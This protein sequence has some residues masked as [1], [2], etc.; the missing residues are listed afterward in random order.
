MAHILQTKTPMHFLN[1]NKDALVA[2]FVGKPLNALRTPAFIVDRAVF[3]ENCRKMHANARDWGATFRGHLKTHKTVEGTRLQLVSDIG[4]TSAVVV[5]TLM[6]AWGVVQGG[7]VADGT[8]KD[9]LY[10]LPVGLN[11]LDDLSALH[12]E[13]TRYGGTVRILLDHLDQV[14]FLEEYE[15]AQEH[16]KKWSVFI[17]MNGGLKRAGILPEPVSFKAFM[18]RVFASSAISVFGF[19]THAGY[20]YGSTSLE[21]ATSHLTGEVR[22]TNDAAA[23]AM[24]VLAESD[25]R[26][27]SKQ[28]FVLSVG[29]TPTALSATAEAKLK[30][31]STLNGTLELHTGN[32][33]MLDLQ[34]LH[35]T[36][37]GRPQIS[38]K[39]LATMISYYPGRGSDGQDEAMCDAGAIAMSKDTGRIPGFGEV[40]G[41]S[42]KLGRISQEHGILVQVPPDP[43]SGRTNPTLKIGDTVEIVGQHACLIA[44]AYPWYYIIDSEEGSDKV[45]DIWVPWKGW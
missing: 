23:M 10:G 44:A 27:V 45:V 12:A 8:V 16:P 28:P 30:M 3:A 29:S 40:V 31:T 4:R 24:E 37:I 17:K 18:R 22:L 35:T 1:P 42:W 43:E 33:T 21:E 39:V 5:S 15:R 20:S 9:I 26:E 41:K 13:M 6:E 14:K 19:Y 36:L 38:Q 11:K 2:D 25:N 7:L 32:Y 34:Q